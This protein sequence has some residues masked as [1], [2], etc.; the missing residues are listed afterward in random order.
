MTFGGS[1]PQCQRRPQQ[2]VLPDTTLQYSNSYW[3]TSTSS[4]DHHNSMIS[5]KIIYYASC[6]NS[7]IH[8]SFG[9][10]SGIPSISSRNGLT[11]YVM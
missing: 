4:P 2:D 5:G 1:Y 3:A 6:S 11:R 10:S 8:D 7:T 9:N